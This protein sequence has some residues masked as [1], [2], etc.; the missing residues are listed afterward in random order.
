MT[1]PWYEP[2]GIT[3]LEADG[4]RRVR[5]SAAPSAASS[6]RWSTVS[7]ASWCHH[8]SPRALAARLDQLRRDPALARAM[9]RAGAR[10]VREHFTWDRVA[11]ELEAV[12]ASVLAETGQPAILG[13]AYASLATRDRRETRRAA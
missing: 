7:P 13:P 6:I 10:R 2:F 5:S 4:L 9:G 1:T 12:Y 3:P 8:A 11:E